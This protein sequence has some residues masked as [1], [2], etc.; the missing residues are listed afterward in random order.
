[1]AVYGV[2]MEF[3]YLHLREKDALWGGTELGVGREG[4]DRPEA[5]GTCHSS[6][7]KPGLPGGFED[8]YYGRRM[9][10]IFI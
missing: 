7:F 4:R 5:R 8:I 10:R 2:W 9:E 1:M 6:E 3:E